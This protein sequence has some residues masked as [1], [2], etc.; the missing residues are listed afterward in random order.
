MIGYNESSGNLE[1]NRQIRGHITE[2][3]KIQAYLKRAKENSLN[4]KHKHCKIN[5]LV[6]LLGGIFE[7][8]ITTDHVENTIIEKRQLADTT[9]SVVSIL[10]SMIERSP[11]YLHG[12]IAT[13]VTY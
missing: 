8:D 7:S 1:L 12:T 4:K 9:A 3:A 6:T 2:V 10:I 5:E 11:K 13:Y